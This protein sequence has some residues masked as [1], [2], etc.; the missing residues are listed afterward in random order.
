MHALTPVG[1]TRPLACYSVVNPGKPTAF[2]A[3]PPPKP[4]WLVAL[5]NFWHESTERQQQHPD[6]WPR[7]I[8][9]LFE[10]VEGLPAYLATFE[11]R[12]ARTKNH[13]PLAD[14]PKFDTTEEGLLDA[15]IGYYALM[16]VGMEAQLHG[17]LATLVAQSS[18]PPYVDVATRLFPYLETM[19]EISQLDKQFAALAKT[20]DVTN[21]TFTNLLA[22]H[23]AMLIA[24]IQHQMRTE[25]ALPAWVNGWLQSLTQLPQVLAKPMGDILTAV[26]R[27]YLTSPSWLAPINEVFYDDMDAALTLLENDPSWRMTPR[28]P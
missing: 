17:Q 14:L 10:R 13:Q 18:P 19:W 3:S 20:D 25:Y 15:T 21:Q 4:E 27:W 2:G 26:N 11:N 24:L 7:K 6:F 1:I 23:D 5:D 12:L 9:G 8:Q 22:R 28:S 16:V